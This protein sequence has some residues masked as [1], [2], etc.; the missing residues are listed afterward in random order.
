VGKDA[1]FTEVNGCVLRAI[2]QVVFDKNGVLEQIGSGK[3][4]V[5]MS[6]VDAA[7]SSKISEAS[8]SLPRRN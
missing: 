6:T 7:T 1:A 3:G 8:H 5:D 2:R 4:Y